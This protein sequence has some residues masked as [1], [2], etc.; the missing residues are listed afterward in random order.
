MLGLIWGYHG[1]ID[2]YT[3]RQIVVI[4]RL[5]HACEMLG[6]LVSLAYYYLGQIFGDTERLM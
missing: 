3:H 6:D 1:P 2:H 4:T 5:Y